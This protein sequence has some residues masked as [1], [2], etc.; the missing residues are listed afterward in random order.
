[1][2][3]EEVTGTEASGGAGDELCRSGPGNAG[4]ERSDRDVPRGTSPEADTVASGTT[5]PIPTTSSNLA[6]S[7]R[8]HV[9][10]LRQSN[11]RRL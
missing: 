11:R 5:G 3:R 6:M 2:D 9:E 10:H 7:T 4:V 1:M 8:F